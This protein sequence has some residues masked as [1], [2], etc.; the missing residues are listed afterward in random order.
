VELHLEGKELCHVTDHM[1]IEVSTKVQLHR[2]VF[3][4][5]ASVGD[6]I[7]SKCDTWAG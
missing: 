3:H 7:F 5:I 2:P 1:R 4:E 6:E